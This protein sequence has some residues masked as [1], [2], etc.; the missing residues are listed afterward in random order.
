MPGF[1]SLWR[2]TRMAGLYGSRLGTSLQTLRILTNVSL[3]TNTSSQFVIDCFHAGSHEIPWLFKIGLVPRP[4]IP[5]PV[6]GEIYLL[7]EAVIGRSYP[8]P[9][10]ARAK[11]IAV[12]D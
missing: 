10:G 6:P 1:L 8:V 12:A 11:K 3:A 9:Q 4:A 7:P 5:R 2:I